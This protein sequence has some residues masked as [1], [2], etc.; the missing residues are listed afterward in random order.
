M[1]YHVTHCFPEDAVAVEALAS[2]DPAF[3]LL[4]ADFEELCTWLASNRKAGSRSGE[5]IEKAAEL[6]GELEKEIRHTLG[7]QHDN[8][9]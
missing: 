8:D 2:E 4:V 3:A 6:V 1:Y 5:E 9:K 7:E